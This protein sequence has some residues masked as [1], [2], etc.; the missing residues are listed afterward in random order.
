MW[1]HT[2]DPACIQTETVVAAAN[3]NAMLMQC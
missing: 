3:A 1:K 2:K